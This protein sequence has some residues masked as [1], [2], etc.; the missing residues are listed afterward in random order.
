VNDAVNMPQDGPDDAGCSWSALFRGPN[1]ARSV[2][3]TGGAAIHALSIRVVVTVLPVAVNEIGGLRF[4]AWTMTVAMVSA[5]WGSV[6]APPLAVSRGLRAAYYIALALFV[7]GS[8]TCATSPTM[9]VFLAGRLLQGLGG[10]LLTALAYT[11]ISRVFPGNLH[12]RAIAML[13]GIWGVASLSGPLLGGILTG[14]GL[15]RWAF[16]I[17]V[18]LAAAVGAVA[19]QTSLTRAGEAS[20]RASASAPIAFG[21]LALLGGSVFAVAIGGLSGGALTSGIGIAVAATLLVIMLRVDSG[22]ARCVGGRRLMPGGAFDPR[23][24]VGAVSLVIAL[25]GGCTMAVV[26]VPYVVTRVGMHSVITAGYLT[27]LLPLSWA[28]AALASA[29][30]GDRW[31]DRLI[32]SGPIIVSLGLVLTGSALA[33]GS[34][35]FIAVALALVGA[36]IGAPWAYLGSLLVEFADGAERD[37]AAAF[38]STTALLSQAFGAAFSGTVANIAGFGDPA[39]GPAG[40]VN[41]ALW[42]FLAISLF[43]AAALPAAIRTLRLS[44]QMRASKLCP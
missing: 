11:T 31:A 14:W 9:A 3:L 16:W 32:V 13:S 8:G 6:L 20:G 33:T 19:R 22:A 35:A 26:Y 18:P 34:L 37:A 40:I 15:W 28:V 42:L 12:P 21:R 7:V 41:A 4:F 1:L 27:A 29:S 36:G 39:L 44:A 5:I 30:A 23:T 25:I 24:P 38:I 2:V 43:P 10:G 17:D